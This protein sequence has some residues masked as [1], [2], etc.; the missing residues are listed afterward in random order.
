MDSL[1]QTTQ[2]TEYGYW[3]G[4]AKDRNRWRALVISV[5]NLRVPWNAGK[6][7]SG[8]SSSAQLHRVSLLVWHVCVRLPL[9]PPR[10]KSPGSHSIEGCSAMQRYMITHT[11]ISSES[12]YE[13]SRSWVDIL[14]FYVP[15]F[16]VVYVD[17]YDFMMGPTKEQN[18]ILCK[19]R[20][21]CETETIVRGRKHEP[22]TESPNSPRPKKERQVKSMLVILLD[23]QVTIATI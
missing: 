11:S 20:K 14:I 21:K 5:L 7:S 23:I 3:I 1:I 18:Q 13:I 16:G 15:L 19:C 12:L 22:Y 9:T 6:L 2:A 4:L 17:W 10:R 8:L